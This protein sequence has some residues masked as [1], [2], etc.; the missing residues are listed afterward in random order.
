MIEADG[1][2]AISLRPQKPGAAAAG[3]AEGRAGGVGGAAITYHC[4]NIE[5][6]PGHRVWRT[7]WRQPEKRLCRSRERGMR[8]ICPA[9]PAIALP[10]PLH[11]HLRF[12]NSREAGLA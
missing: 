10:I 5:S 4:E 1:E 12:P 6:E 11:S 3:V 9:A 7:G 8:M 2:A